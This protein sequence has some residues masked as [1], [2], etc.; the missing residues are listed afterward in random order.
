MSAGRHSRSGP[1]S[2]CSASKSRSPTGSLP[3]WIAPLPTTDRR[4]S[5]SVSTTARRRSIRSSAAWSSLLQKAALEING[6]AQQSG[7][8]VQFLEWGGGTSRQSERGLIARSRFNF[9]PF[10]TGQDWCSVG[11]GMSMPLEVAPL[12]PEQRPMVIHKGAGQASALVGFTTGD[13]TWSARRSACRCP[14]A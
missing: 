3:P 1:H 14:P 8:R 10:R 5:G 13:V 9:L 4:S 2:V 11:I 6:T 12:P 7:G